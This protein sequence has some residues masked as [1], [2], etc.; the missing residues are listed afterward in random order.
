[1]LHSE[2]SKLVGQLRSLTVQR[3]PD[4]Q[5]TPILKTVD[6]ARLQ[7]L[8]QS[9]R[10]H[11][12]I[13]HYS[14]TVE[15]GQS[16]LLDQLR[17]CMFHLSLP[18]K[19]IGDTLEWI[20]LLME[21]LEIERLGCVFSDP[22]TVVESYSQSLLEKLGCEQKPEY[23]QNDLSS[24]CPWN[25]WLLLLSG[26]LA[27][28]PSLMYSRAA[29]K[30]ANSTSNIRKNLLLL[31]EDVYDV[32]AWK[33]L[34]HEIDGFP[35]GTVRSVWLA[36]TYFFPSCGT[37]VLWY[38]RKEILDCKSITSLS[39]SLSDDDARTAYKQYLRVLNTFYRH[40]PLCFD[41]RL[42]ELFFGFIQEF[43]DPDKN[44]VIE[45][46]RIALHRDVGEHLLSTALWQGYITWKLPSISD[47]TERCEW[48]KNIL[49]RMLKT[50]LKD[51]D[52]I[53][54]MYDAFLLTE[55]R[56][57][58]T[59][60][61]KIESEKCYNRSRVAAQEISKFLSPI[62]MATEKNLFLPRPIRLENTAERHQY[63]LDIW[64]H[65]YNILE[66]VKR[67]LSPG[68]GNSKA[69]GERFLRFLFMRASCFPYQLDSW[70]DIATLCEDKNSGKEDMMVIPDPQRK[71]HVLRRVFHLSSFFLFHDLGMQL[72]QVD[73]ASKCVSAC[74]RAVPLLKEALLYHHKEVVVGIKHECPHLNV[75]LEHL[76][77]I[78]VLAISWMRL[79]LK[80]HNKF[81]IRLIARYVLHNV[82]FLSLCLGVIRT[83]LQSNRKVPLKVVFEPFHQF[84]YHW[85]ELELVRNK[86]TTEALMILTQWREPIALLLKSSNKIKCTAEECGADELFIKSC[87][88]IANASPQTRSSVIS[89]AD[90]LKVVIEE[91]KVE[92]RVFL[93]LYE[94][95]LYIFFSPLVY[96]E[97]CGRSVSET[98]Q[99]RLLCKLSSP[100]R[101][102]TTIFATSS[103]LTH[104][105]FCRK[106]SGHKN[107]LIDSNKEPRGANEIIFPEESL[108]GNPDIKPLISSRV[109]ARNNKRN[110]P[111]NEDT[112][113]DK[114]Q[115]TK[116]ITN[117]TPILN[118]SVALQNLDELLSGPSKNTSFPV[119]KVESLIHH[120]PSIYTY[121]PPI[122][123]NKEISLPWIL[124]TMGACERL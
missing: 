4:V 105:N 27:R 37:L 77:S 100:Q 101:L 62:R 2:L 6:E 109:F 57:R 70:S 117:V 104:F 80:Q 22:S 12:C 106:T 78:A 113:S 84:C 40:L 17:E 39:Q 53:K 71:M 14:R 110:P 124:R 118:V 33:R 41:C 90:S 38:L 83:L 79:P 13:Y 54:E 88:L 7:I 112:Q 10:R 25:V 59:V 30:I 35:L 87:I 75:I 115:K 45:L 97:T 64:V 61:E 31:E 20:N 121:N 9:L 65:W 58:S 76:K 93:R 3:I 68:I 47:M 24:A 116:I 18:V 91:R 95:M 82:D 73:I 67:P 102:N 5:D 63:E 56:G 66:Y 28:T 98:I 26:P 89:I 122:T 85:I 74:D 96:Q 99:Q 114:R 72:I 123:E 49:L 8:Q 94:Q 50:P 120:L 107:S 44:S 21:E 11:P 111:R 15:E 108:W 16:I 60:E 29:P 48:K 119:N 86:A 52:S 23:S 36:A 51:L 81:Y 69:D 34:L 43:I 55:Y 103:V 32:D 92:E 46:Y 1:M 19:G 42:Y